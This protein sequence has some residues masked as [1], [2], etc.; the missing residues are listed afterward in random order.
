MKPGHTI[1]VLVPPRVDSSFCE[2]GID[3]DRHAGSEGGIVREGKV[4]VLFNK[5]S[6]R[7][8][9]DDWLG[10]ESHMP[11]LNRELRRRESREMG[12]SSRWMI[13]AMFAA[14]VA[15]GCLVLRL[16]DRRFRTV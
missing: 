16:I 8:S 9:E 1:P 5:K 13:G 12:L 14:G 2:S 4:T 6:P 3:I 10:P 15:V 7:P 11:N